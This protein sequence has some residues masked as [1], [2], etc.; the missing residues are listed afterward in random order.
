MDMTTALDWAATRHDGVLITLRKDGRAQSSDIS[1]LC[2]DGEF[3]VSLTTGRAK[4][5]NMQRDNRVVMHLTDR[6][7]WSYLSFD[8]TVELTAPT[9]EADDATADLLVDYYRAISG[10]HPDWDEYRQAMID[11]GRLIARLKPTSVVGQ[12][13]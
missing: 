3:L 11:E 9:T 2:R 5:R 4:T 1:Y 7:S 13:H 6:S 10:E 12:I 8:A